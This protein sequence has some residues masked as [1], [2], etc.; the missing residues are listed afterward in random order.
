MSPIESEDTINKWY[1]T[2]RI[3]YYIE[4][5]ILYSIPYSQV[6][7][8]LR[9][10]NETEPKKDQSEDFSINSNNLELGTEN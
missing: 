10:K 6:Q 1:N 7:V 3:A 9:Y 4:H 8:I 2:T 5:N